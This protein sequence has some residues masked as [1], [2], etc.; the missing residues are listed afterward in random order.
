[1]ISYGLFLFLFLA[2]HISQA[3]ITRFW[4]TSPV[5]TLESKLRTHITLSFFLPLNF[6]FLSRISM[7]TQ[8][9]VFYSLNFYKKKRKDERK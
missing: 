6:L 1:M 2:I 7:H 8:Y 4:F 3:W 5:T 9:I